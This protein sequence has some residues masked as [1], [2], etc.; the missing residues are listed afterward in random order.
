[1]GWYPEGPGR[2]RW[3]GAWECRAS[4]RSGWVHLRSLAVTFTA[5][6]LEVPGRK[7]RGEEGGGSAFWV[8]GSAFSFLRHGLVVGG[9]LGCQGALPPTPA[10]LP[11][12]FCILLQTQRGCST[13]QTNG[14]GVE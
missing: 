2:H 10:L 14:C 1:M 8:C 7:K 9:A 12:H 11:H 3:V 5:Y 13:E 4:F 6:V